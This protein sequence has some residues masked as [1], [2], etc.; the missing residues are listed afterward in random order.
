M[1]PVAMGSRDVYQD[2]WIRFIE[3]LVVTARYPGAV[4][5][6]TDKA[7]LKY[8]R[9]ERYPKVALFLKEWNGKFFNPRRIHVELQEDKK[10]PKLVFVFS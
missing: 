8:Y 6:A 4:P 10:N 2:D 9:R 7:G 1:Y 5:P 3:D